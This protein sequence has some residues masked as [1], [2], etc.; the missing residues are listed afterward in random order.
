M[1]S[2]QA[3]QPGNDT[4]VR[5]ESIVAIDFAQHDFEQA[6]AVADRQP[7]QDQGAMHA[8]NNALHIHPTQPQ[9]HAACQEALAKIQP[10]LFKPNDIGIH[11]AN[12]NWY[13]SVTLAQLAQMSPEGTPCTLCE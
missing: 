8:L 9:L 2:R 3:A 11:D 5:K 12:V 4:R 1:E 13:G 7:G 10:L 6:F